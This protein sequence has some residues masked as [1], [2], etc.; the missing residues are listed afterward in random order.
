MTLFL[1]LSH[2][3]TTVFLKLFEVG[4]FYFTEVLCLVIHKE[5][6]HQ[7]KYIFSIVLLV[8]SFLFSCNL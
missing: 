1:N 7:S 2:K 8:F 4:C 6:N 5:T 3:Y